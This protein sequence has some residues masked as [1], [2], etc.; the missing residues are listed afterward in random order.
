MLPT[1][2]ILGPSPEYIT[3][4]Y[5]DSHRGLLFIVSEKE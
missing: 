4:I 3:E 1:S 2:R 5:G